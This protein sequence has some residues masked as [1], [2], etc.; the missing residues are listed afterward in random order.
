MAPH[1]CRR[2]LLLKGFFMLNFAND[3]APILNGKEKE[4]VELGE[5]FKAL[6]EDMARM[7]FKKLVG[8]LKGK[9]LGSKIHAIIYN[10]IVNHIDPETEE[11][12][13]RGAVNECERQ[14]DILREQPANR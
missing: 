11:F 8:R 4:I 1:T 5:E 10:A 13:D 14:S 7:L 3:I 9:A 12:D 6:Y 2:T